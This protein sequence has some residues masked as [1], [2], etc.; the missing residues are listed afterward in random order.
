MS[1]CAAR[2]QARPMLRFL[3]FRAHRTSLPATGR[4]A[5]LELMLWASLYPGLP[6]DPRLH[7]RRSRP[8]RLQRAAADPSRAHARPLP[9]ERTAAPRRL[10]GRVSLRLLH[11]RLRAADRGDPRLAR[12]P[13]A[14]ALPR[15][16]HAA[17]RLARASP[18]SSTSSTRLRRRGWFR[19]SGSSTRSASQATT[20][21]RSPGSA[22][23]PTRRCRACTS[24][25]A[26]SSRSSASGPP[27]A[28]SCARSSSF[29][30]S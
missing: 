7:D 13:P 5:L 30:H 26:S 10:D 18:S 21:G 24:A 6:R 8:G 23:T 4:F 12:L 11:G 14:S 9:R 1:G 17:L 22:S 16:P 25:G 20:P 15:P 2:G 27:P 29:I 28:A 19:R 3:P